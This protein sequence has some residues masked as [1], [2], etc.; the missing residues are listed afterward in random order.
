VAVLPDVELARRDRIVGVAL[1]A[2]LDQDGASRNV[3][4]GQ[5]RRQALDSGRGKFSEQWQRAQ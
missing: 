2:L 1:I 3:D 4:R 5:G